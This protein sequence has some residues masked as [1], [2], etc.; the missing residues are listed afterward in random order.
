M[1]KQIALL[2]AAVMALSLCACGEQKAPDAAATAAHTTVDGKEPAPVTP[3]TIPAATISSGE[4]G[5]AVLSEYPELFT[6]RV[7]DDGAI[8]ALEEADLE[9]LRE[10]IS[11]PADFAAWIDTQQAPYYSG[12]TSNGE[13]QRTFGADFNFPWFK[14][15]MSTHMA[16]SLAMRI[17]GDDIP[18]LGIAAVYM[19]Y[20]GGVMVS[21][22]VIPTDGG[23]YIFSLDTMSRRWQE[24]TNIMSE[25]FPLLRVTELTDLIAYSGSADDISCPGGR[26]TQA[27]YLPGDQDVVLDCRFGEFIP[28]NP[29]DVV[30]FYRDEEYIAGGEERETGHIKPEYIDRYA[31]S[32]MLGGTTLTPEEAYALLDREPEEVKERVRTAGDVLMYMLAA[33]IG[34]CGG[35]RCR[36]IDGEEWHYNLNAFEVMEQRLANCGASANL[37]NYLLEGDYEEI[38]FILHA[39]YIGEGGGHVY[40]Y[41]RHEGKYY[42]VDFSWY[43]FGNYREENDFPVMELERL[44]DYGERADELYG[45]VCMILSHTSPGQHLPNV[46]DEENGVYAIPAGAEHTLLRQ[47]NGPGCFQLG[48]YPLDKSKL[49]WTVFG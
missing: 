28:Q 41:I 31:L 37:A 39:Y 17:L 33:R 29:G 13:G 45:G 48:E 9:T 21:G 14:T 26:P 4:G 22:S 16:A 34:D 38:G 35:D 23:Y 27:F 6:R 7:L 24:T 30:E 19:D 44:E 46:F 47:E 10:K 18:G 32:H 25:V 3:E 8:A 12:I 2:L 42:I 40:N 43:I 11:T 36:L 15:M 1:R 49:D 5:Y 20:D